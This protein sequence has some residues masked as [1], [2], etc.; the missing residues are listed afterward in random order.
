MLL[1]RILPILIVFLALVN[2]PTQASAV[3]LENYENLVRVNILT[4][5]NA[6][7]SLRGAYQ[8]HNLDNNHRFII[9][10][11]QNITI[12]RVD[13]GIRISNSAINTFST[14]GFDVFA[15]NPN[16]QLVV[17][18]AETDARSGASTEYPVRSTIKPGEAVQFIETFRNNLGEDWYIVKT[19][20]GSNRAV[21]KTNTNSIITSPNDAHFQI[22]S[23]NSYNGSFTLR[24]SGNNFN[25]VNH[26]DIES[27]LKG[28]LPNEMPA[29]FHAEALNAQAIASR[30]FAVNG[31]VLSNTVSSQVYRG[32]SSQVASTNRAVDQTKGLVAKHNGTV[33][34]TFF[35]STSGGRTANIADVWNT[36]Q[37]PFYVS[38]DDPFESI[39]APAWLRNWNYS[40]NSAAI[41][42]NFRTRYNILYSNSSKI[43]NQTVLYDI[44]IG[45]SGANGE[46]NSVTLVTSSGTETI[47]GN[48]NT[49]RQIFPSEA[50]YYNMLLSSWFDL[51]YTKEYSIMNS[52]NTTTQYFGVKN[53]QVQ[54]ANGTT[55]VSGDNVQIQTVNGVIQKKS[56][57]ETIT[58]NGKGWGHR[59][60]MSQYG[61]QGM[62][63]NGYTGEQIIKHYFKGVTV[64][65]LK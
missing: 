35:F 49:I 26:L 55:T 41:L 9:Q 39:A 5:N 33:V 43:N 18:T 7:F 17:V 1:K 28:V 37:R 63:R 58:V 65:P 25:V 59:I 31:G 23:S 8:I 3:N 52:N 30:S 20:D 40:Y 21:R 6:T 53:Q 45:K 24:N 4:Q 56:D 29:S 10:P 16:Q 47:T 50:R 44:K 60:G 38:V 34:Q 2:L 62:A 46:V 14:K 48:E 11:N 54:L 61:A 32:R 57:P 36:V 22:I 42:N 27:Y 19:R 15:L 12:T 13:N 51:N 64:E